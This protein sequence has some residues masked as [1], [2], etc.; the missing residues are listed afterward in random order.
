MNQYLVDILTQSVFFNS[1]Q[2]I[3]FTIS[4]PNGAQNIK[5]FLISDILKLI[6]DF[7]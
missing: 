1:A 2:D 3:L 4:L 5:I 7:S 6:K